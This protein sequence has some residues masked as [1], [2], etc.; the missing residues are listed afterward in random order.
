[1][2]ALW[3]L[4]RKP[5]LLFVEDDMD[6]GKMF[7]IY[8]ENLSEVTLTTRGAEGLALYSSHLFDLVI[9]DLG[10]HGLDEYE[11]M[12]SIRRSGDNV[13]VL[14]LT[15]KDW[16]SRK[17]HGLEIDADDYLSKP[18]DIEE[19]KTRIKRGLRYRMNYLK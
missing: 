5:R 15:Q 4:K 8:F 11:F 10:V 7:K 9:M 18:F 2:T 3:D 17:L 6:L 19:V 14:F 16:P 1:M 12:R 13:P